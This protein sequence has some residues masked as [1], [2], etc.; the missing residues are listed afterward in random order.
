MTTY[1]GIRTKDSWLDT[2]LEV[3]LPR[4]LVVLERTVDSWAS[5]LSI[6]DPAMLISSSPEVSKSSTQ[7]QPLQDLQQTQ[8]FYY[9]QQV[10]L[11]FFFFFTLIKYNDL[12]K[13]K[14]AQN[15]TCV[16]YGLK[17]RFGTISK[18]KL[19]VN[20]VLFQQFEVCFI[21]FKGICVTD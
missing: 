3:L 14:N 17:M 7:A 6:S 1:P 10:K 16:F 9:L 11:F 18:W 15:C 21:V 5:P 8:Q 2:R 20:S 4:P 19:D 13:E 12:P